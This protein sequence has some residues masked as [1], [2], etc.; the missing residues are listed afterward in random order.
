MADLDI[1]AKAVAYLRGKQNKAEVR[2]VQVKRLAS[3]DG[4]QEGERS[5]KPTHLNQR[6]MLDRKQLL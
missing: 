3:S 5:P 1:G 4:R 6:F 2:A